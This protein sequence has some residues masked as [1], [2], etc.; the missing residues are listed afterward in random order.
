MRHP[1]SK[2]LME[3]YR[4]SILRMPEEQRK[5]LQ[6]GTW[7]P[8]NKPEEQPTMNPMSCFK[9]SRLFIP[10]NIVSNGMCPICNGNNNPPDISQ[11]KVV[12][13]SFVKLQ[14]KQQLIQNALDGK[15]GEQQQLIAEVGLEWI[16]TLL[17]KNNDYG[18]SVFKSPLLAP[19]LSALSAID[20]RLSDKIERI[21]T[22]LSKSAEVEESVDDT[23][24]DLGAYCLLRKVAKKINEKQSITTLNNQA[25]T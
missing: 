18:G 17:R 23:F 9:C 16:Y 22:L 24:T 7:E 4:D 10:L 1:K 21:Q 20:V 11:G 2:E 5:A 6:C 13:N 25:T 12:M 15:R 3:V 8:P 14:D 19:N